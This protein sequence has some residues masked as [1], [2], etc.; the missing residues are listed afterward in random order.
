V[1]TEVARFHKFLD[2]GNVI[3]TQLQRSIEN[4]H[5]SGMTL[6]ITPSSES[7]M[8]HVSGDSHDRDGISNVK[9]VYNSTNGRYERVVLVLPFFLEL[10]CQQHCP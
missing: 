9:G 3:T 8:W 2:T 10:A 1:Y 4:M 5:Y 7:T 6:R